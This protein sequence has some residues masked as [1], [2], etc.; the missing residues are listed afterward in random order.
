MVYLDK[1]LPVFD[2]ALQQTNKELKRQIHAFLPPC[3]PLQSQKNALTVKSVCS[4]LAL[5][6]HVAS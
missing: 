6:E 3:L 1:A 2:S 5:Q 4:L